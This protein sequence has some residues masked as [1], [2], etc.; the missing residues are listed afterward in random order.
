MLP[1]L[2][3]LLRRCDRAFTVAEARDEAHATAGLIHS[4]FPLHGGE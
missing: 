2:R 3:I 1:N 4:A